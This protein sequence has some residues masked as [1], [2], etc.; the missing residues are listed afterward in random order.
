MTAHCRRLREECAAEPDGSMV[1]V[2]ILVKARDNLDA[3]PVVRLT[4]IT[5]DDGCDL[6]TDIDGAAFGTDDRTFRLRAKRT[7]GERPESA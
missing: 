7:A 3:A 2:D 1:P 4:A 5:C 6:A